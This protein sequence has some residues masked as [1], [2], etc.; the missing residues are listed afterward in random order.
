MLFSSIGFAVGKPSVGGAQI[1]IRNGDGCQNNLF[2]I[3]ND[4]HFNY[5]DMIFICKIF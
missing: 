1:I 5:I 2:Q 4:K 3:A